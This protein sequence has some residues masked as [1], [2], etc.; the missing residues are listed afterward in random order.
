MIHFIVIK[1]SNSSVSRK[2]DDYGRTW[3]DSWLSHLVMNINFDL[4]LSAS[5]L[6]FRSPGRGFKF[7]MKGG[8][9]SSVVDELT[10]T[11]NKGRICQDL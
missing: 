3:F 1:V 4:T 11:T 6:Q 9:R 10:Q 2:F 8:H 7:G 5:S